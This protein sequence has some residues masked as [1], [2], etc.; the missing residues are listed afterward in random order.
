M[1]QSPFILGEGTKS[2]WTVGFSAVSDL[3]DVFNRFLSAGIKKNV[4][5][6]LLFIVYFLPYFVKIL[7]VSSFVS[8][9]GHRSPVFLFYPWIYSYLFPVSVSAPPPTPTLTLIT[10][11][12][13]PHTH[14]HTPHILSWLVS[15]VFLIVISLYLFYLN[16]S[17]SVMV[18]SSFYPVLSMYLPHFFPIPRF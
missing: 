18:A 17:V 8:L 4:I 14:T 9:C 7:S 13:F 10:L 15:Q 12:P 6:E 11:T 5:S 3:S 1:I 16:P 2:K